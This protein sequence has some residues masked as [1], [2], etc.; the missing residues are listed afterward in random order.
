MKRFRIPA[1]LAHALAL[2]VQAVDLRAQHTRSEVPAMEVEAIAD[3]LGSGE[4]F[5][6]SRAA[7]PAPPPQPD[8]ATQEFTEL[9]RVEERPGEPHTLFGRVQGM[10]VG[11]DGTLAVL[12]TQLGVVRLIDPT[13]RVVGVRGRPGQGPGEFARDVVGVAFDEDGTLWVADPTQARL[14]GFREE[15]DGHVTRRLR[16]GGGRIVEWRQSEPGL[17]WERR[18]TGARGELEEVVLV[19]LST[20]EEEAG[21]SLPSLPAPAIQ[22][23]GDSI[24]LL[25][26]R[27]LMAVDER[28]ALLTAVMDTSSPQITTWTGVTPPGES[29]LMGLEASSLSDGDRR[30]LVEAARQGWAELHG[31][32]VDEM[33]SLLRFLQAPEALP[34]VLG[35]APAPG[36][37]FLVQV[38]AG[39]LGLDARGLFSGFNLAAGGG[40]WLRFDSTGHPLGPTNLPASLRIYA[41]KDSIVYGVVRDA[42]DVETVVA[43]RAR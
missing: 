43:Y 33:G 39:I 21:V 14:T 17:V 29:P 34:A 7:L 32:T 15:G 12:D 23:F 27:H 8:A 20:G 22:R 19:R 4:R 36:G 9:F 42:W 37:G 28:G 26:P 41:V 31:R 35:L 30:E 10:A 24:P 40:H 3:F 11:P 5:D 38:P 13:G 6:V 1:L 18:R 2:A 25:T 16:P